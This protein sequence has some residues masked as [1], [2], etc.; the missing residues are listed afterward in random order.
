MN[1]WCLDVELYIRVLR[2]KLRKKVFVVKIKLIHVMR[3]LT[4]FNGIRNHKINL[5]QVCWDLNELTTMKDLL[6][7]N[8]TINQLDHNAYTWRRANEV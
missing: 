5:I 1:W 7:G 6:Q 3:T 4:E 8:K 2:L